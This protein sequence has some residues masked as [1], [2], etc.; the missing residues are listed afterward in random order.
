MSL[1]LNQVALTAGT[2]RQERLQAFGQLNQAEAHGI[3]KELHADLQGK[4]GVLRLLHTS[5]AAKDMKFQRAGDFK[6][7]FLDKGKI[8]RAG[9][10]LTELLK[11]AGLPQDQ[12]QNFENYARTRGRRGVETTEVVRLLDEALYGTAPDTETALAGLGVSARQDR[13]F[14]GAGGFG[15]A[16]KVSYDGQDHV[17]KLLKDGH[18][19]SRRVLVRDGQH[20]DAQVL[21]MIKYPGGRQQSAR[22]IDDDAVPASA[23]WPGPAQA[24]NQPVAHKNSLMRESVESFDNEQLLKNVFAQV[25]PYR[26]DS[27]RSSG[28]LRDSADAGAQFRNF[29]AQQLGKDFGRS[30]SELNNIDAEPPV[31]MDTAPDRKIKAQAAAQPHA[32]PAPAPLAPPPSA[33]APVGQTRLGRSN[34]THAVRLKDMPGVVQPKMLLVRERRP[35]GSDTVHTVPGGTAFKAWARTRGLAADLVVEGVLMPL[36]PGKPLMTFK[37]KGASEVATANVPKSQLGTLAEQGLN[38]LKGLQSRGFIHGDIKPEN[39]LYDAAQRQLQFIDTDDLQK[40]SKQPGAELPNK[41]GSS[42]FNYLHP[43]ARAGK[44][45]GAGR[46]LFALGATLLETSLHARGATAEWEDWN[47][48]LWFKADGLRAKAE[49]YG[50]LAEKRK[51]LS[52]EARKNPFPP[53]SAEHFALTCIAESLDY[54]D[55]R[56]AQGLQKRFERYTAGNAEHPLNKLSQHPFLA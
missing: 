39:M 23:P 27:S 15:A 40:I 24:A 30:P 12:V 38:I 2:N 28:P 8:E 5:S 46:D 36:A 33:A 44:P 31:R 49:Y 50:A 35:N 34:I 19:D 6:M 47:N 42:T 32:A 18:E 10:A 41:A 37:S 56:L 43:L 51:E 4:P 22:Q 25:D 17:L 20:D 53:D 11:R 29:L 1:Q 26:E 7:L 54:E 16:Y 9:Q 45:C 55:N 13:Q 14:L 21:D 52:N 48:K 3:L